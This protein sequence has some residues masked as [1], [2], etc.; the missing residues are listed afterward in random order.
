M[1]V[2]RQAAGATAGPPE[3]LGMGKKWALGGPPSS[4]CPSISSQE[5][6]ITKEEID[7]LSDACSKLKEQKQPLTKEKEEL[8]LL[9][10][11][12]QDYSEV[13]P[14]ASLSLPPSWVDSSSA[15]WNPTPDLPGSTQDR[16]M[17]GSP[18]GKAYIWA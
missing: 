11:D 1:T 5:E 15:R 6:E 2:P 3:T 9:K 13:S 16:V 12:V 14:W 7:I 18:P 17:I 10:E 8:E 4:R